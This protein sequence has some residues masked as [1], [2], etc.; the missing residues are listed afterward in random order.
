MKKFIVV[1]LSLF[2]LMGCEKKDKLVLSTE[3]GFEPFEYHNGG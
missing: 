3:A 2:L 1:L